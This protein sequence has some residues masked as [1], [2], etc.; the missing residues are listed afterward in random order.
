[1][2]SHGG[3]ESPLGL[4][5]YASTRADPFIGA[6]AHEGGPS[7]RGGRRLERGTHYNIQH[8]QAPSLEKQRAQTRACADAHNQH[9]HRWT[10]A[11]RRD[12]DFGLG[13]RCLQ[14]TCLVSG[15]CCA[16]GCGSSRRSWALASASAFAPSSPMPLPARP[17]ALSYMC[18]AATTTATDTLAAARTWK[19]QRR[20]T[21]H[22]RQGL[23]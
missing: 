23:S 17:I 18:A 15:G 9:N 6:W 7:D 11:H 20:H 12:R 13:C 8:A 22:L 5:V 1:M 19:A 21:R 2:R 3:P 10:P 14:A 4:R 16:A